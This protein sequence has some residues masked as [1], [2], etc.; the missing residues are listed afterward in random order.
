MLNPNYSFKIPYRGRLQR[1]LV[2]FAL[3]QIQKRYFNSATY[4]MVRRYEGKRTGMRLNSTQQ[5]ANSFRLYIYRRDRN[6]RSYN[7]F[8]TV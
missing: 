1:F 8:K 6:K 7:Y 5:D 4:K 3:R 2:D